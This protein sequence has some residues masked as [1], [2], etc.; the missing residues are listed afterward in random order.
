[1]SKHSGKRVP[2]YTIGFQH[3]SHFIRLPCPLFRHPYCLPYY[4][5]A[6][7]THQGDFCPPLPLPCCWPP[8]PLSVLPTTTT[9][10]N[11]PQDAVTPITFSLT[12]DPPNFTHAGNT[13]PLYDGRVLSRPIEYGRPSTLKPLQL[14][15]VGCW[16][17]S[18]RFSGA[19][20]SLGR[21]L[22]RMSEDYSH[23]M[24]R[25]TPLI[26]WILVTYHHLAIWLNLSPCR[27]GVRYA[28]Q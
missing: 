22:Q 25:P 18:G 20:E 27:L 9:T 3:Q 4:L 23:R 6:C 1:M 8:P 12:A 10:A 17:H 24:A 15:G 21:L 13:I 28:H 19:I 26:H 11:T 2:N 7:A 16:L 14:D 5:A